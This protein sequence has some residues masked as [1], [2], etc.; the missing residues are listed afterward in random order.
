[1]MHIVKSLSEIPVNMKKPAVI[2]IGM[3]DS[4]H[5]GHQKILK[6]LN[7]AK[8]PHD[9]SVVITFE[10]HP[11]TILKPEQAP[12]PIYSQQHKN[13]LLES[14]GI[15]LVVSLPFTKEIAALSAKE[16]LQKIAA[17]IPIK[18][19]ILGYDARIGKNR[20]GD[21]EM[22]AKIANELHFKVDYVEPFIVDDSPVSSTKIRQFIKAG[23]LSEASKLLGRP[24][25]IVETIVSG[26]KLGTKMGYPTANL[27]VNKLCLPPFGIYVIKMIF[28][29]KTHLGVA[30]LGIAPTVRKD[31]IPLLEVHLFE[32]TNSLYGYSVEVILEKYL[33]EERTFATI[34]ALVAQIGQDVADAKHYFSITEVIERKNF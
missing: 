5:L 25:S 24:Y 32:K 14:F 34:D 29:G 21:R 33:R 4:V 27:Q 15:D 9:L 26:E 3:F 22:V 16:F 7:T 23:K 30:N 10:N 2:T 31:H 8:G 13:Q 6:Q 11:A 28:D 17:A 12:Q 1:M 20:E 18:H 19:L